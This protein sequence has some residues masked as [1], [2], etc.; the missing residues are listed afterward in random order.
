MFGF[1]NEKCAG[2]IVLRL[3]ADLK[4]VVPAPARGE[5]VIVYE[6]AD[7]ADRSGERAVDLL[8]ERLRIRKSERELHLKLERRAKEIERGIVEE[9][10]SDGLVRGIREEIPDIGDICRRAIE[11]VVDPVDRRFSEILDDLRCE[12]LAA[13]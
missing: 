1:C 12:L 3:G 10:L 5:A 9:L 6:I 11:A 4:P 8:V 13:V 7:I 2:G